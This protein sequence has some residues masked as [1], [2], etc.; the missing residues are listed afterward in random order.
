MKKD[1]SAKD[2][3]KIK[4]S[5]RAA[6]VFAPFIIIISILFALGFSLHDGKSFIGYYGPYLLAIIFIASLIFYLINRSCYLDLKSGYK[7]LEEKIIQKKE[8][9]KDFEAGSGTQYFGQKMK[10]FNSYSFIIEN[11][12]YK[13]EKETFESFNEGDTIIF[14]ITSHRKH[15]LNMKANRKN[16]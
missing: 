12:R 3:K 8:M 1:L 5:C 7:I 4:Y 2:I 6:M 10:S 15:L 14:E 9:K 11:T 16:N 13:V